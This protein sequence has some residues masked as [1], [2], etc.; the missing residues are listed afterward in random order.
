VRALGADKT[1]FFTNY[2]RAMP[3][4]LDAMI[5]F[6]VL[7]SLNIDCVHQFAVF[8]SRSIRLSIFDGPGQGM[9]LQRCQFK[10]SKINS[11]SRQ[12]RGQLLFCHATK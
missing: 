11:V 7:A 5:V 8:Y 9:L 2:Q 12:L 6:S 1:L 3:H 10:F 4:H